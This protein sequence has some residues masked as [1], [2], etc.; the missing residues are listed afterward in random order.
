MGTIEDNI[1]ED[2]T[3]TGKA[4]PEGLYG[5]YCEVELRFFVCYCQTYLCCT[6]IVK[7]NTM[8]LFIEKSC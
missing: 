4:C 7:M 6:P 3:L 8:L 1:G 2:G 5:L